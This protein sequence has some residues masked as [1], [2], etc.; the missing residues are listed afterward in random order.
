MFGPKPNSID[1]PDVKIFVPYTQFYPATAI[2]LIGYNYKAVETLGEFGYSDYFK[3]RWK[4]KQ[5]FINVEQ[6][7]VV[8]PGALKALW[9]CPNKWCVYD[10]HLPC[11]QMRNLENEKVGIPVGCMKI[12]TELID[13]TPDI[14]DEPIEW[15]MCEQ[16]LTKQLIKAGFQVHQHHPGVVNANSALLGFTEIS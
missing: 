5:T 15:V 11:H 6:D 2:S 1:F 7:V 8:Y 13:K 3:S 9:N 10:F 4:D 12:S 16:N 14:W